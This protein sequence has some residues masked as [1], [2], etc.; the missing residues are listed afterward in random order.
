M[1]V[2]ASWT[3]TWHSGTTIF[4]AFLRHR[5]VEGS[6]M[7][8]SLSPVMYWAVRTTLYSALWS[9]A[10]QLPYQVVMQSVRMLS[11]VQL[12]N[13]EDLRTRAKSPEGE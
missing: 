5:L 7:A 10:E 13:L 9:D 12:Y 4:M 2:E 6:W 11:I 1:G 3:Y 8:G